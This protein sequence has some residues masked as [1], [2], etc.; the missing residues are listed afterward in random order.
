MD[1]NIKNVIF[2]L[3]AKFCVDNFYSLLSYSFQ[4]WCY[5]R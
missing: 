4:V 2:D 3:D 1:L 5:F